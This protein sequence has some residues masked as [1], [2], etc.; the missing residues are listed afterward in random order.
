VHN[1]IAEQQRR[2][3]FSI[4][5]SKARLEK[6]VEQANA[7][8]LDTELQARV[9]RELNN[10]QKYQDVVRRFE[11]GKYSLSEESKQEYVRAVSL[12][13]NSLKVP[14][15]LSTQNSHH[16][17]GAFMNL[18]PGIGAAAQIPTGPIPIK[19]VYNSWDKMWFVVK[20]TALLGAV[21]GM[22]LLFKPGSTTES[23]SEESPF[24]IPP[25]HSQITNVVTRFTD[26]KGIEEVKFELAEVVEYLRDPGK[27]TKMGAKLPKGVM[28][29]GPP[30]T[31]KTLLA[32]AIAGEAGVPFY[33]A[34]GASFDELYVGVGP[35][36]VRSLFDEAR[37][38]TPCIIFID[39]ID[40]LGV[41][42]KHSMSSSYSKESTLNQLL[43]ELDGFQPADGIIVIGATNFPDA[44]DSALVRPGRFDKIIHVHPPDLNG[45]TE[46][47][48]YYLKKVQ[49]SADI[50]PK[51]LA[52]GTPGFTGADLSNMINRAAI[53]A[54]L[55]NLKQVDMQ[56]IEEAKDEILMGIARKGTIDVESRKKTA[57]HEGGHALASLFAQGA[58]P[59]HK[60]TIIPRGVALGV[61]THLPEKDEVDMSKQ[62]IRARLQVA[63]GGRA[64]EEII[65]GEEAVTTGCSSDLQNATYLAR[66][67]VSQWGMNSKVGMVHHDKEKNYMTTTSEAERNLIDSEVKNLLQEAYETVKMTL[68][69]HQEEL[70]SL[71]SALLEKETLTGEEVKTIIQS[72]EKQRAS[73][74]TTTPTMTP[75][76]TPPGATSTS[77]LSF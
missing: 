17:Y 40:S 20:A 49:S 5:S 35:K 44:L 10:S 74:P 76:T 53:K 59:L 32:R 14:G 57:Y 43:T 7:A 64:A 41:S 16:N 72:I 56:V 73:R 66:A 60:V 9:F 67:M 46:I 21:G 55:Q 68:S 45:R 26:V 36:R 50:D 1:Q 58:L 28:L 2:T 48:D 33:Y 15:E 71:A 19:T 22:L 24:K 65:F 37:N 27:F 34:S 4:F 77:A 3:F 75:T 18:Q 70:H 69:Q 30:G 6:L 25:A 51:V 38:H 54:V 42:R 62:Q 13:S 39:E 23:T 47:L 12:I 29:V 63:L 61:T 8:P 31:G 11:S 52:R